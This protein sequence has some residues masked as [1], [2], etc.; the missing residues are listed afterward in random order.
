VDRFVDR[1]KGHPE[2]GSNLFGRTRFDSD[3]GPIENFC[4]QAAPADE[5]LTVVR[6]CA[7]F[8]ILIRRLESHASCCPCEKE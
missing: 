5:E 1:G 4:P 8:K 2:I 3:S 6:L 7:W